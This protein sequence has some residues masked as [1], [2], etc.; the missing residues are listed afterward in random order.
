MIRRAL[1][2][3]FALALIAT[4]AVAY[5]QTP[6]G[7]GEVVT[8]APRYQGVTANAPIPAS[9]HTKNE[10]G[11]DNAGLCVISS[12]LTNGR[13]Q[14]VPGLELG[15]A[16]KLWQT[17]KGR[18]GGYSPGK[19]AALL[20]EIMPNESYTSYTGMDAGVLDRWSRDGYPIGA[21]M[22]YGQGYN[23]T[24]HHMISLIHYKTGQWACVVDNNFIGV[25]HWMPAKEFDNRWIDGI[26]WAFRWDRSPQQAGASLSAVVILFVA[27][28][29][30]RDRNAEPNEVPAHA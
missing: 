9:M 18:P 2:L 26:G 4:A 11:S 15:K 30:Y 27:Y 8:D 3:T 28:V 24:I 21:T 20:R 6:D 12:I 23:G 25:Y 10:G 16:S 1:I 7:R 22:R 13:F 19:L 5:G 14:Q 17:A 29:A